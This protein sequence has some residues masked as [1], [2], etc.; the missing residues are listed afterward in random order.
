M[1]KI[2]QAKS[3]GR[4]VQIL[5]QV[6]YYGVKRSLYLLEFLDNNERCLVSEEDFKKY[7]TVPESKWTRQA[8]LNLYL[9]LFQGRRDV[10]AKSFI[11]DQGKIQYYPS[12][13]YGWRQLPKEKR[14][15]QPLTQDVLVSHLKGET[16]IGLFPMSLKDTCKLLAIDLD[17]KDWQAA[18]LAIRETAD[19]YNLEVS[20]EISRS[21]KGAHL[22][23]F[24]QD[25]ILCSQARQFGRKL[26]EL[27]MQKSQSLSFSSF[28]RFFPNQDLLPKGGFGN[29]IALPLQGQAYSHG[30]SVFVDKEFKPY[31]NQWDYL[32]GLKKISREKLSQFLEV[33]ISPD[34]SCKSTLRANLSNVIDFEKADLSSAETHYLKKLA[35]F[36]NPEFY[37]KQASRQPTYNVPERLYLYEETDTKL[38]I[39]RGLLDEI[40]RD[41]PKAEINNH[42]LDRGRIGV[43][44]TGKLRFDQDSALE[45]LLVKD[46]GLLSAETGF[47]K[48]VLGA[49]LIGKRQR[50]TLILV[51]N[52]Q[53]LEQWLDRLSQFLTFEEEVPVRYTPSG[54]KKKMGHIGQYYGA[55]K[56]RSRL[57]DVAMIQS[58]SKLDSVSELV[59]DYDMLLVDE[60]HHTSAKMFEKV[61]AAFAGPYLYGFPATPERKN[62]HEP[63]VFQ[64]IGPILHQAGA[65]QVGFNKQLELKFTGFG[66]FDLKKSKSSQFTDLMEWIAKDKDR[67]QLILKDCKLALEEGRKILVLTRRRDHIDNLVH[68]F[69]AQGIKKVFALSG[70]SKKKERQDILEQLNKLDEKEAFILISTGSYIGEG[71]DLPQLDT[72]VLAA[73]LSW[74]NNLIQY[75][76]RLHRDFPGKDFVKII[77]Y[78]DIH[79]PYLEKMFH[80]RQVAY[81]KMNYQLK[82]GK[83]AQTLYS[84]SN[85]Q[86]ALFADLSRANKKIFLQTPKLN[87]QRLYEFLAQVKGV[88][89]ELKL[90]LKEKSKLE[91]AGL[92]GDIQIDAADEL[93]ST[94]LLIIDSSIV[95]YGNLD[96]L[97][98]YQ[99]EEGVL[100]RLESWELAQEFME[101]IKGRP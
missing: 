4:R 89:L 36:A 32:A 93:V 40:L 60:C 57:V 48:T 22:W 15:C 9:S 26:L 14:T 55:K 44:F 50:R 16:S 86:K 59:N 88:S 80:K 8:K 30:H 41:F 1:I 72:L 85:Y 75:A 58:L 56:W 99:K 28:D 68:Q 29:L 62:G 38:R 13:H 74:K 23:F 33:S 83:V 31:P 78:I 54:R 67:N 6:P 47:G 20:V 19:Y 45:D 43:T 61:V 70:Q 64:R 49:A 5:E 3:N 34:L 100:L 65:R 18:S 81:R 84:V 27:A 46:N 51:H 35:S 52:Q 53:L 12:Y 82:E 17:K 96:I 42:C 39:P 94:N 2:F 91:K 73:P 95:W 97:G 77:D 24:F 69:Q 79:V 11:N 66:K 76:G 71:F 87:K 37:I 21:G 10:Y 25:E 90:P 98:N 7:F 92:S 101:L 63:I